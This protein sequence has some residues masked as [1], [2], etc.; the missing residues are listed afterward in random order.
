MSPC[1]PRRV[2]PVFALVA[3]LALPFP[4]QAAP[5]RPESFGPAILA[6]LPASFWS[7]AARL[8]SGVLQKNGGTIDPNGKPSPADGT[9]NAATPGTGTGDNGGTIDPNG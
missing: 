3:G 2:L 9:S 5:V 7:W 4:A 1:I 6:S 8:W